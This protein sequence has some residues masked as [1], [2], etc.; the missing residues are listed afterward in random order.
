MK[1]RYNNPFFEIE[2]LKEHMMEYIDRT[3]PPPLREEII[4]AK[5][6]E[7]KKTHKGPSGS[8]FGKVSSPPSP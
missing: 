3:S 1:R 8:P 6:A 5:S 4:V 7:K 2:H